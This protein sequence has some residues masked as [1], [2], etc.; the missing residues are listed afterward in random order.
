MAPAHLSELILIEDTSQPLHPSPDR[1]EESYDEI[2]PFNAKHVELPQIILPTDT[3]RRHNFEPAHEKQPPIV[4][5]ETIK[6][7]FPPPAQTQEEV[8]YQE[9]PPLTHEQSTT[10]H[11]RLYTIDEIESSLTSSD[12]CSQTLHY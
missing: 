12:D 11:E 8:P 6:W 3:Y 5:T 2:K 4:E 7:W 9:L 10:L 1:T